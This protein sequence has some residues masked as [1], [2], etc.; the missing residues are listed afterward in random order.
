MV[1]RLL[2]DTTRR[3]DL[4]RVT[5][6]PDPTG[7]R[8][9]AGSAHPLPTH[10]L[11]Q[12]RGVTVLSRDP[13]E[14]LETDTRSTETMVTDHLTILLKMRRGNTLSYLVVT[15]TAVRTAV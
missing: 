7:G 15:G 8:Q 4:P 1:C 14:V 6:C 11:L 12:L 13:F 3:L 9:L 10:E 2:T 5:D